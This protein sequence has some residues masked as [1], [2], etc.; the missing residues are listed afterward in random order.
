MAQQPGRALIDG[1]TGPDR[2]PGEGIAHAELVRQ[3]FQDYN[4]TLIDFLVI[5]LRS[6][7][8]AQD[9]AQ[10]AYVR[11]LQLDRPDTVGF[12][13]AYYRTAKAQNRQFKLPDG[14]RIELGASSKL[15]IAY[16][17]G[18]RYAQLLRGEAYFHVKHDAQRPFVVRP[19]PLRIQDIGTAFDVRKTTT[20]VAI[21]VADG[22]VDVVRAN[23]R[24]RVAS[25]AM[26]RMQAEAKPLRLTAGHAA[27]A[28]LSNRKLTVSKVDADT[29]ASWR[30]GRLRFQNTPLATA[31]ATIDRYAPHDIVI[32]DPKVGNM[33]FT[34]TVF[35]NRIPDWLAA[36]ET[37][38][39][40]RHERGSNGQVLLYAKKKR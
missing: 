37:V 31:I 12:L 2:G 14:T 19:G 33:R 4:R 40:L 34:G 3:L 18:A 28:E 25:T 24:Q 13:H 9:V 30:R 22:V 16:T 26:R 1:E 15:Q 10:E 36:T 32:A 7:S 21:S 6:A 5:K 29:A 20:H 35:E 11:L 27:I 38:F 8:E 23:V 17:P 39:S